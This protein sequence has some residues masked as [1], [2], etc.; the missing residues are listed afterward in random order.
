MIPM[1]NTELFCQVFPQY[2]DFADD[3]AV[4]PFPLREIT[5][6]NLELT[7]YLLMARYGNTPIANLSV[8]QFRLKLFA[9]IFQFAPAWQKK[10]SIQASLRGLTETQL[11][12]GGK[13]I[14]NTALNPGTSP[15]AGSLEELTYIDQQS[16]SNSKKSKL[17]AYA[18]LWEV[19]KTDVTESYLSAFKHLFKQVVIPDHT[20]IYITEEE[21]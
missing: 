21:N 6:E 4:S 12:E 8:E 16:T 20:H 15:S 1:Y 17:G 10:M 5:T 18:E 11:L 9:T 3:A 14:M 13:T 19:L 7:Y 2:K